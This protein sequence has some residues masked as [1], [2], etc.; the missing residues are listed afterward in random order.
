MKNVYPKKH[1]S[2]ELCKIVRQKIKRYKNEKLLESAIE[3]RT[4]AESKI[5]QIGNFKAT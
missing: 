5:K 1:S 3:N 4:T 2:L